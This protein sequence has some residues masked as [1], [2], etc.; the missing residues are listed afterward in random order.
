MRNCIQSSAINCGGLSAALFQLMVEFL[1]LLGDKI[2]HD[3]RPR[4]KMSARWI[5]DV[6]LLAG[7]LVASEHPAQAAGADVLEYPP[8]QQHG[9]ALTIKC[10]ETHGSAV[11][12]R[13][14]AGNADS[15]WTV[16]TGELP[17]L[18]VK[19]A[20]QNAVVLFEVN[21]PL[22]F[23]ASLQGPGRSNGNEISGSRTTSG[24]F[25]THPAV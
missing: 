13:E 14:S 4:G 21:R 5:D 2:D 6:R 20:V 22:R 1:D 23:P 15:A 9:D 19:F 16:R 7:R 3:S 18:A 24:P 8:V 25:L 10:C 17:A 12:G 11:V